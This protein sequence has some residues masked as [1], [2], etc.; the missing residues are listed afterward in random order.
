MNFQKLWKLVITIPMETS[1]WPHLW[2]H[3]DVRHGLL[4]HVPQYIKWLKSHFFSKVLFQIMFFFHVDI[5]Q[6]ATWDIFWLLPQGNRYLRENHKSL[7]IKYMAYEKVVLA[8]CHNLLTQLPIWNLHSLRDLNFKA[9]IT[10]LL[11]VRFLSNFHQFVLLIFSFP[12][13]HFMT[14]VGFPFKGHKRSGHLN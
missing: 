4:F 7:I 12:T 13:Q 5:K 1:N 11:L 6:Y 14:K 2:C 10:F 3:S 8:P 9:T